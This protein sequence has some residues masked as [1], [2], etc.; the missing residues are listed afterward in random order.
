MWGPVDSVE[1]LDCELTTKDARE[2]ILGA[3]RATMNGEFTLPNPSMDVSECLLAS[4]EL[5]VKS[6][7]WTMVKNELDGEFKDL[8]DWISGGCIGPPEMLPDH[9]RQYWRVRDKLR[10]VESVPMLDDRT[11]VPNKLRGPVLETLHSAHQEVHGMGLRAEQ[12][13]YWPGF[14]TDIEETRTNCYTCQKI[15]PSQ[16]KLPPVELLVPNYPSEYVCVDYMSLNGHQFGVFVDTGWPGVFVGA[17]GFDVTKFLAR[18]C[19]DYGVPVSCTS[20][21][22]LNLTAKVVEDMIKD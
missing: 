12:A 4:M 18:L 14:W 7:S 3:V 11:V 13:V 8:A 20:D 6:V 2:G 5:E 9:I 21:G 17:T 19:E 10:L 16:A 22:G 15:A 1:M